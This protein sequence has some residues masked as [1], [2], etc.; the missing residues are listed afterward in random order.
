MNQKKKNQPEAAAEKP[1]GAKSQQGLSHPAAATYLAGFVLLWLFCSLIYGSVFVRAEQDSFVTFNA[2]QMRFLTDQSCG[3][4]YWGARFLLLSFKSAWLGGL[5][6]SL[7][8]T[9]TAWAVNATLRTPKRL[10]GLG[11]I[12]PMALLAYFA[13]RGLNIWHKNE[14]GLIFLYPIGLLLTTTVLALVAKG[15]RR[16]RKSDAAPAKPQTAGLFSVGNVVMLLSFLTLSGCTMWFNQNEILTSRMQ[17]KAAEG[18]WEGIVDDALSARRP[19]RAVA[20]YYAIAL[21]QQEQLLEHIFDIPFDYPQNRL[22]LKEANPEYALFVPEANLHAGLVNPAY[23]SA[24]ELVVMNGPR[25]HNLKIM[26]VCA[27]L[28]D[29]KALA[30]KLLTVIGSVPFEDAFVEKF[31]PM[32]DNRQLIAEQPDL[33]RIQKLAPMEDKF[34]QNY[35]SPAF[36]GYNMGLLTGPNEALH[37]SL[38][39]CLYSKDLDNMI[40]RANILKNKQRLPSCVQEA[41]VIAALKRDKL[42]NK[43]PGI[44]EFYHSQ[45]RSF[46]M[47]A[48][49]YSKDKKALRENLKE[50]WLGTYTYYYYCENNDS[51]QVRQTATGGAVN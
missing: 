50:R 37:T 26:A 10:L 41:L 6:L 43:F 33:V 16:L 1:Q 31:A 17:L 47:D 36:L 25:L 12:V 2:E 3:Y 35:R 14:P 13:Y 23:H 44:S 18:D 21:L 11:F 8:L 29:E 5:L 4:L 48:K 42:L 27:I 30:R 24:M 51:T 46:M 20:S 45:L 28:N 40:V 34:E 49:P 9:A 32:I 38:A 15:L 7:I 19:T 39:A 22:D